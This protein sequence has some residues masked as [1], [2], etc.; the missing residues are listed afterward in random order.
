MASAAADWMRLNVACWTT[1][2]RPAGR[3]APGALLLLLLLLMLVVV[4]VDAEPRQ[5]LSH[6]LPLKQR[7]LRQHR[8]STA[9]GQQ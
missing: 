5:N 6:S 9:A 3:P 8:V 1:F 4:A 7:R 2:Y